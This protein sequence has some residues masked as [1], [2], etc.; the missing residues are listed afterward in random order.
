MYLKVKI[1]LGIHDIKANDN[2]KIIQLTQDWRG[3]FYSTGSRSRPLRELL[4]SPWVQAFWIR[5]NG[6]VMSDN[7]IDGN[8]MLSYLTNPGTLDAKW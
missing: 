7:D 6:L 3:P 5:D 1:P 4:E 2:H 8:N